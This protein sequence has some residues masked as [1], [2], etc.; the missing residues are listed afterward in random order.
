MKQSGAEP[1]VGGQSASQSQVP[2][3]DEGEE[4]EVKAKEVELDD[5]ALPDEKGASDYPEDEEDLVSSKNAAY[6][7]SRD[8]APEYLEQ[9]ED[10]EDMDGGD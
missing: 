3:G 2:F 8:D 4:G 6:L 7:S 5:D 9:E 1:A 10:G